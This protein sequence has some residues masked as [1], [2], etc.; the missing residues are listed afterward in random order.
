MLVPTLKLSTA[1]FASKEA[2]LNMYSLSRKAQL[3]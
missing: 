2:I 3:L 1:V